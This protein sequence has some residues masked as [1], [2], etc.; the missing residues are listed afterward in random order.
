MQVLCNGS[1]CT[2]EFRRIQAYVP[3]EDVT[4]PTMSAAEV[5]VILLACSMAS[6]PFCNAEVIKPPGWS[7][8]SAT[9][10]SLRSLKPA[11]HTGAA[12]PCRLAP[13][14]VHHS[15]HSLL[16][17]GGCA[18]RHGPCQV[19]EHTGASMLQSMAMRRGLSAAC[20]LTA[21]DASFM[22][23]SHSTTPQ[24]P[25]LLR[26][27][28]YHPLMR[29]DLVHHMY[30]KPQMLLTQVGGPLPGGISVRGLSG[31][32]RRRLTIACALVANPSVL[33]L[34]EPTT[35][36]DPSACP[37]RLGAT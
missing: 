2:P 12:I 30:S 1:P 15:Q 37:A 20:L 18:A 26:C 19:Q 21:A 28:S 17:C 27:T 25:S 16:Y 14:Q 24:K 29:R 31:G 6:L 23:H 7:S 35:G 5:G 10:E 3:Q 9:V 33:F 22:C 13:G 34:D 32:E 8:V 36:Q 4:V 11:L